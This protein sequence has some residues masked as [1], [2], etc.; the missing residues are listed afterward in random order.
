MNYSR[1]VQ[2]VQHSKSITVTH[3]TNSLKN[4]DHIIITTDVEKA[5]DKIQHPFILKTPR[6]LRTEENYQLDKAYIPKPTTNIILNDE[7]RCFLPE[8]RN[9]IRMSPPLVILIQPHTGSPS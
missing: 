3:H 2:L 6:K 4:E 8:M 9:K 1:Y 7:T 5:M